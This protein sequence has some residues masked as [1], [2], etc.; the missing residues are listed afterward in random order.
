MTIHI[1]PEQE[2][3]YVSFETNVSMSSYN[4]VIGRVLNA[5]RPGKFVLTFFANKVCQHFQNFCYAI[6]KK[7]S[8]F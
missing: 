4:E 6:L 3:S 7:T 8:F 1:T 5:F 2:F